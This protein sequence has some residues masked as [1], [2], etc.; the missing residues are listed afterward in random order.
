MPTEVRA[1]MEASF[2]ADFS[3]VRIHEGPQAEAIGARA[4]AQGTDLHFA[5]GQYDPESAQGQELLGHE[6]AHVVQQGQGRAAA[7][8][9]GKGLAVNADAGLEHEADVAGARAARGEAAGT[10]SGAGAMAS[11]SASAFGSGEVAQCKLV[12]DHMFTANTAKLDGQ[13]GSLENLKAVVALIENHPLNQQ[14]AIDV[15]L[16]GGKQNPNTKMGSTVMQTVDG[17]QAGKNF[18]EL[19][20]TESLI[21]ARELQIG[22]KVNVA[23]DDYDEY[24]EDA[25]YDDEDSLGEMMATFLHEVHLHVLPK[26]DQLVLL[27]NAD[28]GSPQIPL[29]REVMQGLSP[30]MAKVMGASDVDDHDTPGSWNELLNSARGLALELMESDDQGKWDLAKSALMS[31]VN[32]VM[33][34]TAPN[35]QE[36]GLPNLTPAMPLQEKQLLFQRADELA[37]S[38]NGAYEKKFPESESDMDE[39]PR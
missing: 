29:G 22:V 23:S 30:S 8:A 20:M 35:F 17:K 2:G 39:E 19:V 34:H 3:A 21:R 26:M 12:V 4:Y 11:A 32:D 24:E 6:L 28:P 27:K 15:Y 37:N 31:V 18:F 7:T 5:P 38:F 9:Q 33:T 25:D 36:L 1:K 14:V 10:S 16:E 13:L